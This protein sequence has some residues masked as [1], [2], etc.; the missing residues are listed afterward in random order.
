MALPVPPLDTL[1]NTLVSPLF[2]GL[3]ST[4][5]SDMQGHAALSAVRVLPNLPGPW[6]L[7]C[8]VDGV[9]ME[10]PVSFAALRLHVRL[11]HPFHLDCR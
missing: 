1:T 10:S 3:Q 7:Q 11:C 9:M 5:V 8:G 2:Y 6:T 4:S